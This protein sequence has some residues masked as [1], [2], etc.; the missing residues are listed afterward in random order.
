MQSAMAVGASIVDLRFHARHTSARI[1]VAFCDWDM[2]SAG[3]DRAHNASAV[4]TWVAAG[5]L[6][7]PE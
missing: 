1:A 4:V 7:D 2:V 5:V 3:Q 6:M